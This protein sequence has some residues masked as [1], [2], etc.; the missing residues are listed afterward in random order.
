MKTQYVCAKN[1]VSC[2]SKFCTHKKIQIM[3]PQEVL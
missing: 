2:K 1:S 3:D